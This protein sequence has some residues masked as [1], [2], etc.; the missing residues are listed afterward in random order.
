MEAVLIVQIS[1][2]H[3]RNGNSPSLERLES[4]SGAI[5]SLR[6]EAPHVVIVITGDVA[7]SGKAS[8]YKLAIDALSS[9][10]TK[11]LEDWSF[12]SVR[13]YAAPGNHD[14]DFGLLKPAVREALLGGLNSDESGQLAVIESLATSQSA[15][16][17]FVDTVSP[18]TKLI[19]PLLNFANVEIGGRSLNILVLNTS[20]SSRLEEVPGS[21]RM[22]ADALQPVS[23]TDDLSIALLH[24]PL[25]WYTPPDG[26]A[27]SDW[28]DLHADIAFWG[29]EHRADS[30]QVQRKKF[31]SSV[32]NFL[33]LP[34]EDNSATCGFRVLVLRPDNQCDVRSFEWRGRNPVNTDQ[35]TR[36][37][38]R[39]RTSSS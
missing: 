14:V 20:W 10:E 23:I 38:S 37:I 35:Y 5:G 18:E 27:L 1:D 12:E 17:N 28:L 16:F 29:H 19:S 9:L 11:L 13:M 24:H 36:P 2:L 31:G 32:L 3:I 8:E 34:I 15:F 21:L 4:L 6:T 33:A 30:F 25:N 7:F 22:P 39:N 26:K